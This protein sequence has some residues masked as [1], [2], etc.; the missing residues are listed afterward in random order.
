MFSASRLILF[1]ELTWPLGRGLLLESLTFT[2]KAN[3]KRQILVIDTWKRFVSK[4]QLWWCPRL[5]NWSSWLNKVTVPRGKRLKS[6][7]RFRFFFFMGSTH[8]VSFPTTFVSFRL[9]NIMVLILFLMLKTVL[10]LLIFAINLFSV[11][12][13]AEP[14]KMTPK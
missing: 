11:L 9:R 10:F 3:G 5:I 4:A 6:S 13:L 1:N 8:I 14:L 2:Y 7:W 12:V